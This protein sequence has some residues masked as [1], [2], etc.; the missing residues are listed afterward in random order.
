MLQ[1]DW[2]DAAVAAVT[3]NFAETDGATRYQAGKVMSERL[4]LGYPEQHGGANLLG[5][6]TVTLIPV[7]VRTSTYSRDD[8]SA[9][10]RLLDFWCKCMILIGQVEC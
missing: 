8:R 2:N 3:N 9:Y 4:V 1:D 6:D 7:W 10:C 5:W